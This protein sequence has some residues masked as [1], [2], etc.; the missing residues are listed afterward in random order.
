MRRL[1]Y[2]EVL[3][4][5]DAYDDWTL[6]DALL[7]DKLDFDARVERGLELQEKREA[8]EREEEERAREV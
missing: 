7:M 6:G 1:N 4:D 5:A 2:K 8:E 3:N